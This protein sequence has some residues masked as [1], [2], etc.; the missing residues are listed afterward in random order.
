MDSVEIWLIGVGT[1]ERMSG[2]EFGEYR[3]FKIAGRGSFSMKKRPFDHHGGHKVDFF[4][5]ITGDKFH[6]KKRLKHRKL[7][8][9]G[10]VLEKIK[11][12]IKAKLN[13]A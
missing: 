9:V 2:N 13:S 3:K 4:L 12:A 5:H 7:N 11:N 10:I 8:L 1:D 6:T